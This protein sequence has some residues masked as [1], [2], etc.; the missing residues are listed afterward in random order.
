M[1][2]MTNGEI[3]QLASTIVAAFGKGRDEREHVM[4]TL[5]TIEHDDAARIAYALAGFV[6]V[7]AEIGPAECHQVLAELDNATS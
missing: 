5:R 6:I 2:E 1:I 3:T 4:Q 7:F